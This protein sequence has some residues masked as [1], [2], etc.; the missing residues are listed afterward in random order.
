M[1]E[2]FP[3]CKGGCGYMVGPKFGWGFDSKRTRTVVWDYKDGYCSGCY[4]KKLERE[5]EDMKKNWAPIVPIY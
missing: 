2:K 3:E 1:S 5:I 4:V